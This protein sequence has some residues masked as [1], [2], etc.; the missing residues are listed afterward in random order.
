MK[1]E[2]EYLNGEK[3][4]KDKE[5]YNNGNLKFDGEF[6]NGKKWN[7]KGYDINGKVLYELKEGIGKVKEYEFDGVLRFEGE[8]LNGKMWNGK[9]DSKNY[10]ISFKNG[11]GF[12]KI[13]KE[14]DGEL[15]TVFEAEYL[16]GE[17]NG[18]VRDFIGK[19]YNESFQIY[20]AF[21][22]ECK[23]NQ[24][25]GKGKEYF[26]DNQLVFEGEYLY[27]QKL[28]GKSYI[29]SKL[30]FEGE[31]LCDKKWEGTYAQLIMTI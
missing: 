6:K 5:Y 14:E 12:M 20:F 18:K 29:D 10:K 22:G 2:G 23:N 13:L 8:Y 19:T 26:V 21:E 31:Y 28:K 24:K 27:N 3:D 17:L 9:N 7:G 30:E 1:F 25:E 11:K 15:K 16:N 4:G